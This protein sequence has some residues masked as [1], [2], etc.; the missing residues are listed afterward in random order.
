MFGLNILCYLLLL[1]IV[2]KNIYNFKIVLCDKHTDIHL[3]Q[4]IFI[5]LDQ[6]IFYIP[7]EKISSR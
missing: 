5:H 4:L 1:N 3:D 2:Y 6:L 7:K